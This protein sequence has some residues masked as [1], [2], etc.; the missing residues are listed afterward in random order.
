MMKVF[1]N[2]YCFRER[3]NREKNVLG[4]HTKKEWEN[5]CEKWGNTCA[6]CKKVKKLTED[7]IIPI[8]L[9]GTDFIENIQPLC[10]S[11]NSKKH[12]KIIKYK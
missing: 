6:C 8:S 5:L 10:I 4:S 2:R 11:C 3:R 1:L 9:G 12:T 7:H